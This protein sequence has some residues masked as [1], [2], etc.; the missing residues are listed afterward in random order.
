MNSTRDSPG[1]ATRELRLSMQLM[2]LWWKRRAEKRFPT[3]EDFDPAEL[4]DVWRN[5]FTLMIKNQLPQSTFVY[6]GK[7]VAKGSGDSG[8]LVTLEQVEENTLLG[9]ATSDVESVVEGKV[10]LIGNGEYVDSR[11]QTVKFRSILLPVSGDQEKIDHIIGGG[12]SK[13]KPS[14]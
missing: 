3:L 7:A 13:A 10:P 2:G 8:Q 14:D 6:V 12:R 9:R 11:G 5:C 4:R 1:L